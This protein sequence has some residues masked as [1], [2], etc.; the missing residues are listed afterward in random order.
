MAKLF[1]SF[2]RDNGELGALNPSVV[3]ERWDFV[4][5]SF[6]RRRKY[7]EM[8][9]LAERALIRDYLNYYRRWT[10]V[11]GLPAEVVMMPSTYTLLKRAGDFFATI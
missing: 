9:S 6:S 2:E 8:F 1:V 5:R 3:V 7:N 11:T 10:L 4:K